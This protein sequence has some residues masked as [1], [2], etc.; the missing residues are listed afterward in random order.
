MLQRTKSIQT[1]KEV[2]LPRHKRMKC[3]FYE[4]RIKRNPRDPP[5]PDITKPEKISKC[6]E[7]DVIFFHKIQHNKK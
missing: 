3:H 1:K 4:Q 2:N 5:P 7:L 6:N